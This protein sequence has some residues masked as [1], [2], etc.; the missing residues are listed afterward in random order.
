MELS[1]FNDLGNRAPN[2]NLVLEFEG[3]VVIK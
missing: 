2:K 3:D 1:F